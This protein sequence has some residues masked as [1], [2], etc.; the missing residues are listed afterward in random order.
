[1]AFGYSNLRIKCILGARMAKTLY[2]SKTGCNSEVGVVVVSNKRFYLRTII[3]MLIALSV[4]G[5]GILVVIIIQLFMSPP[6]VVPISSMGLK[7]HSTIK[8]LWEM[9]DRKFTGVVI[10]GD[11]SGSKEAVG[12]YSPLMDESIMIL[13]ILINKASVNEQDEIIDIDS[14]ELQLSVTNLCKLQLSGT[15]FPSPFGR[16]PI[17]VTLSNCQSKYIWNNGVPPKLLENIVQVA[18]ENNWEPISY[19][20]EEFIS[21]QEIIYINPDPFFKCKEDELLDNNIDD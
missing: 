5:G 11:Q 2:G 16:P 6:V 21:G 3:L 7:A 12:T 17:F 9:D 4:I 20:K 13:A 18:L 10:K 8:N 1:M 15:I 14:M 19:S